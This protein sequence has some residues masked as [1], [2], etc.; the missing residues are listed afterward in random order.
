MWGWVTKQF[1]CPGAEVFAFLVA[2]SDDAGQD[3]MIPGALVCAIAGREFSG[4]HRRSQGSFS[5]I[6]GGLDGIFIKKSE[7]PVAMFDQP[8]GKSGI[9]GIG[10]GARKQTIH[11]FF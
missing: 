11:R 4:D 7:E 6:I 5:R 3:G 2:G 9:V 10:E 8:L 1:F